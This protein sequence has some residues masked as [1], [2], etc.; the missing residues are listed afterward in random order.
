MSTSR[1]LVRQARAEMGKLPREPR[2]RLAIVSCMDA[3][4][5]PWR[6]VGAD[7]GDIHVIRNAGGIVTEDVVRSLV[8]STNQLG[9]NRISV[10][11]H[12]TCGMEGLTQAA[13]EEAVGRPLPFDVGGFASLEDELRRG[14]EVL[15]RR[16]EIDTSGGITGHVY[17][18]DTGKLRLVVD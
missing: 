17:D 9:V 5:D 10:I 8:V 16:A 18:V 15:R 7:P 1:D 14:V 11:M 4:V 13:V 2:L 3:R 6:I 12:T